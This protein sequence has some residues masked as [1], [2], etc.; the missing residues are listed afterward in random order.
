MN[1]I[2]SRITKY[3]LWPIS[4][5]CPLGYYYT[6]QSGTSTATHNCLP[7]PAGTYGTMTTNGAEC[8][9]CP[10]GANPGLIG[11]TSSSSCNI[12]GQFNQLAV[13]GMKTFRNWSKFCADLFS[14]LQKWHKTYTHI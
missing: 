3:L 2:H 11:Q 1:N 5:E 12:Q 8:T 7:C 4:V 10:A 9:Q 6:A 14:V 13:L